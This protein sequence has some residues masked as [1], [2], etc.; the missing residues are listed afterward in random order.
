MSKVT[1]RDVARASGVGLSTVS[2]V[3]NGNYPVHAQTRARV[4]K[5]IEEL[6]YVPDA[7]A[8]SLKTN[9]TSLIGI[10]VPDISATTIMQVVRGIEC[11]LSPAGYTMMIAS[12]D[13]DPAK[14]QRI[15]DDFLG[16]KADA[17][18]LTT[19][20]KEPDYF[21]R[22]ERQGV[23][24]I[25]LERSIHGL[26]ADLVS[27]EHEVAAEKLTEFLLANGHRRIALVN[28]GAQ[29]P[30]AQ[31][32]QEGFIR[33]MHVHGLFVDQR[34]IIRTSSAG[35]AK[36]LQTLF[37]SLPGETWPTAIFATNG[38][39]ADATL[40][41]LMEMGLR[42]PE[43]ISLVAYGNVAFGDH[44]PFRLTYVEQELMQLGELA[45]E[46]ALKRIRQGKRD[47]PGG[48]RLTGAPNLILGNT[49]R[50]IAERA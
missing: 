13:E 6:G 26:N 18:L 4:L 50:R 10:A 20:Q 32:R 43:D 1:I 30:A 5:A 7:T 44:T 21:H 38:R 23:P 19:C 14:E 45:G 2:R 16:R 12:T 25:L 3:V 40:T 27:E 47:K 37:T 41:A 46:L 17:V 34:Y 39:R 36:E 8:R 11:V 31:R 35:V 33:A 48:V 29:I 22:L 49:H 28:G 15:L 42:V 9:K 24:F